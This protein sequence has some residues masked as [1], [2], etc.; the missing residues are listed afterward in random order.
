MRLG[1][2]VFEDYGDLEHW[3]AALRRLGYRAAYCPLDGSQGDEVIQAYARA[4]K[5]ADVVITEV[6]VWNNPLYQ[7]LPCQ[8]HHPEQKA[9][10]APRRSTTRP[11]RAR[12]PRVLAGA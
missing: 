7:E 8:G 3:I 9:H 10:R 6:G 2:P 1:G 5:A 4:A 12:L 11:G